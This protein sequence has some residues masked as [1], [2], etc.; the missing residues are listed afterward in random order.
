LTDTDGRPRPRGRRGYSEAHRHEI[1]QS[2]IA[3][4][5][6][7]LAGGQEMSLRRI[8]AETGRS[9][10]AIYQYFP[11]QRALL[12]AIRQQDMDAATDA[13]EAAAAQGT[14]PGARLR[15]VFLTAARY[16]LSHPDHFDCLFMSHPGQEV[17]RCA[18]GRPFGQSES[19]RRSQALY[20]RVVEAFL[21]SLPRDVVSID[22]AVDVL[23]ATTHGVIAF[24]RCTRS[25]AWT[26]PLPMVE[27]ALDAL[28]SSW[29]AASSAA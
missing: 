4:G 22:L 24:P 6:Q 12:A 15:D 29:R 26:P 17:L 28:L 20:R 21:A 11:D 16:W 23:I 19:V 7:L 10:A 13:M 9:V 1:R 18:D 2:F 8:A 27:C 14:D 5:R 25:M 3:A